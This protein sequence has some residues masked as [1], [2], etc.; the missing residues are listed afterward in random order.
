[1]Y[2]S[3]EPPTVNRYSLGFPKQPATVFVAHMLISYSTDAARVTL[4]ERG[5]ASGVV[6]EQVCTLAKGGDGGGGGGL[7]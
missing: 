7:S 3:V 2:V 5:E 1:L 6:N 4:Q